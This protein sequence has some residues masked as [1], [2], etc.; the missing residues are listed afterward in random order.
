MTARNGRGHRRGVASPGSLAAQPRLLAT[1][2][3]NQSL[4]RCV[5]IAALVGTLLSVINQWTVI[6]GGQATAATWVRVALN[7]VVPFCVSSAGFFSSQ[8]SV[9]VSDKAVPSPSER[10]GDKSPGNS[11]P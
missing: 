3:S 1:V 7:Y 11:T 10:S 9:W 2:L 8:R 5:P 6:L 4:S